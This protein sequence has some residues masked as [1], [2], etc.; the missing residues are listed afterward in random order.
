M[1]PIPT[2][3]ERIAM[4]RAGDI[5]AY[6]AAHPI[7]W[8]IHHHGWHVAMAQNRYPVFRPPPK[9]DPLQRWLTPAS[10]Y[11]AEPHTPPAQAA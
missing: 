11:A 10:R 6:F 8:A 1:R 2:H 4:I 7:G 3:A 5:D 9:I